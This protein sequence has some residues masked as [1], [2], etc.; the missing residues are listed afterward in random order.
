MLILYG[1]AR[2]LKSSLFSASSGSLRSAQ[3][4]RRHTW[5][6]FRNIDSLLS[7]D[8]ESASPEKT[9]GLLLIE[10]HQM[11]L[12]IQ[13]SS[14]FPQR[15]KLIGAALLDD[16]RVLEGPVL[17]EIKRR[18]MNRMWLSFTQPLRMENII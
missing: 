6:V 11:R 18:V 3:Q 5:T 4:D 13:N 15:N 9:M 10:T 16:L 2:C 12:L 14:I 8:T 7:A 17:V 1:V